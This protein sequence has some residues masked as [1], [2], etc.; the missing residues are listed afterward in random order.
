MKVHVDIYG[1]MLKSPEIVEKGGT[2]NERNPDSY[3]EKVRNTK[4]REM[5]PLFRPTSLVPRP[6]FTSHYKLHQPQ[7]HRPF[8]KLQA[9]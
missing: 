8:S 6:F 7:L 2:K 3:R 1:Q 9:E 5:F 4:I